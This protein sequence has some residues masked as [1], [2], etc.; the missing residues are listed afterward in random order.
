MLLQK[1][2]K[3]EVFNFSWFLS[4]HVVINSE[5]CAAVI[6]SVKKCHEP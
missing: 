4:Q 1:L 2:A 3:D 5:L 6:G